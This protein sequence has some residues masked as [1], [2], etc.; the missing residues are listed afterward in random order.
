MPEMGEGGWTVENGMAIKKMS[1]PS[2]DQTY[3]GTISIKTRSGAIKTESWESKIGILTN[4]KEASIVCKDLMVVYAGI[5]MSFT[6]SATGMYKN[7]SASPAT[8]TPTA[9]QIGSYITVS[10]SGTDSKGSRVTFAGQKYLVKKAPKPE[11]FWN[12]ISDGGRAIKSAGALQCRYGDNVPFD[13]SKGRFSVVSYSITVS[14]MKGSLDGQGSS[15][16]GAH[17]NALKGVSG[18]K[19]AIQVRYAGTSSDFISATFNN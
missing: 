7:V 15:I 9:A 18:G 6:A 4:E 11:L 19:I 14:G 1:A 2:G 3:S 17:L 8:V 5:P 16:S 10:A 13:P 12:N